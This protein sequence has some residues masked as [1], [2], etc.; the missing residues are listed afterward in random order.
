M[1]GDGYSKCPWRD[2]LGVIGVR[3]Y[4]LGEGA[5]SAYVP[6]EGQSVCHERSSK[7][8]RVGTA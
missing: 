7:N 1:P 2:S 8:A 4:V 6:G 5:R 3:V